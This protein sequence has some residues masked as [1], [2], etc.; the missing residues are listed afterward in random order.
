MSNEIRVPVYRVSSTV[1]G[2]IRI[3][4]FD[5]VEDALDH[6]TELFKHHG[7]MGVTV[8]LALVRKGK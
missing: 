7:V 5:M 6:A 3:W 8:T 1:R 2:E 4:Q